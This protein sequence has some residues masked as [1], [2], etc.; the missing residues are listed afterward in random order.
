MC[1][2][3]KISDIKCITFKH[4]MYKCIVK[5]EESL[6]LSSLKAIKEQ[7]LQLLRRELKP[8]KEG[9]RL[10]IVNVITRSKREKSNILL[11]YFYQN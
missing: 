1:K 9:K 10:R 8:K 6:L 4:K 7:L 3:V 2:S 11:V 5:I